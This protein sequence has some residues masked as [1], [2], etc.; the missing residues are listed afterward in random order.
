MPRLEIDGIIPV[1]ILKNG[2]IVDGAGTPPFSGEVVIVGGR[3]A[4]VGT[5]KSRRPADSANVEYEVIDCTGC[6][7]APGF[8]DVHSHSDLQVLENRT[9][10]LLQGVRLKS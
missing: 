8:I 10:K 6:I 2:K 9:E 1:T 5:S 7:I 4:C 3:I